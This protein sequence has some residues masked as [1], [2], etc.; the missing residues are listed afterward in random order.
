MSTQWSGCPC[1]ITT[2][3]RSRPGRRAAAGCA[4]VPLPQSIQ[5]DGVAGAHEVAAARAARRRAVRARAPEHGQLHDHASTVSTS[6]PRNRAP[7]RRNVVDVAARD[8]LHVPAACR[9][10]RRSP[11]RRAARAPRTRSRR[12]STRARRRGPS[13]RRSCGR[14]AGSACSRA[15]ACRRRRRAPARAAAR[16]ARAPGRSRRRPPRRTRR[17][18]GTPRR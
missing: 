7:S 10:A 13:R 16:R 17:S 8:E 3:V 1:V 4:N 2:A 6:G 11:R 14:A 12:R 9:P 18:P 15:R 5:I